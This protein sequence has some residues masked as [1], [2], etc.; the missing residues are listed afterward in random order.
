MTGYSRLLDEGNDVKF[1]I[2]AGELCLDFINTLDNRPLPGRLKE[3]LPTYRDLVEWAA[4]AGAISTG[5]RAALARAAEENPKA[6]EAAREK[7]LEF[8]ECFNR[9]VVNSLHHHRPAPEDLEAFNQSLQ[10]AL[11]KRVLRSTRRGFRMEW[12]DS[13]LSFDSLLW[14]VVKSASDLLTSGELELVRQ[15]DSASC[16]WLFLDRSK[17]HSRRWCDMRICG[18]RVKVQRFYSRQ[19]KL[20]PSARRDVP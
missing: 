19:R 12:R 20:S 4:Q 6:A 18:N 7:C 14:P 3:L 17:N 8:R 13:E 9:I 10:E 1:Q 5:Q 2:I 15:C 16:R 11:S